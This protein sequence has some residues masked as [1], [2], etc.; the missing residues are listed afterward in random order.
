MTR[1][2]AWILAA[3]VLSTGCGLTTT[4]IGDIQARSDQFVGREV[5]VSGEVTTSMKLPF[6][7]GFYGVKDDTGEIIVVTDGQIPATGAKVR[8]KGHVEAAASIGGRSL[9][10]HLREVRTD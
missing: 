8:V 7:P 9:G 6:L 1:M 2:R 5:T 4:K 10:I 3:L